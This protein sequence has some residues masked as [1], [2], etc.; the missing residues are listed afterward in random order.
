MVFNRNRPPRLSPREAAAGVRAGEVVLVDVRDPAERAETRP[1]GSRHVPLG[2]LSTRIGELPRDRT[3]SFICRSGSRSAMAA[4]A[5]ADHGLIV[6]NVRGGLL[7]WT[8]AGLPVEHGPERHA[9]NP[10]ENR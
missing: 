6:A 7:A 4:R 3:V 9:P 5:A 10:E 2:D 8:D 1:A